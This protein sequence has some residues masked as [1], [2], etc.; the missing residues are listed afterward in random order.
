MGELLGLAVACAF[1]SADFFGA[2]ASRRSPVPTILFGQQLSGLVLGLVFVLLVDPTV[3]PAG[4]AVLSAAAGIGAMVGLAYLYRGLALGRISVV[5]PL[6][7]AG[8]AAL[9]VGWGVGRGERPGGTVVAGGVLL[10][11]AVVVIAGAV[12]DDDREI[13]FA[14]E[15]AFAT[16][17]ALG[18][19]A[20]F[21]LIAET[22]GASGFWPVVIGR[23]AAVAVLVAGLVPRDRPLLPARGDVPLVV[24]SGLLDAAASVVLVVAVRREMLSLVAPMAALYPA[25]TVVLARIFLHER[26]R[27]RPGVGLLIA[28]VGLALIAAH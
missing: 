12:T 27:A 16:A 21:V 11:A 6:S 18:F 20:S 28:L 14:R 1:G 26:V 15:L 3:P 24:V 8:S 5:A 7:A 10:L 13:T 9:E 22:S 17:A 2:L 4:D 19:A 25:V 23:T